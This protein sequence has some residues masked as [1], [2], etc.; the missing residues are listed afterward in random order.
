MGLGRLDELLTRWTFNMMLLKPAYRVAEM[1]S[2]LNLPLSG[3]LSR[4][5][6]CFDSWYRRVIARL[7]DA[8]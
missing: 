6:L 4:V 8:R 1:E 7:S 3:R 5:E 2:I